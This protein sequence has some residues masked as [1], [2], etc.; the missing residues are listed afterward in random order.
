M[1]S[2]IVFK[3]IKREDRGESSVIIGS[4]SRGRCMSVNRS[5]KMTKSALKKK[6]KQEKN[7]YV[8]NKLDNSANNSNKL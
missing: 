3:E 6:D 5:A 7:W 4:K 8:K 1:A 2:S